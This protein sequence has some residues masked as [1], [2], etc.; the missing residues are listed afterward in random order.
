ML[1]FG[2]LQQARV[3]RLL[4]FMYPRRIPPGFTEAKEVNLYPTLS[5]PPDGGD[6]VVIHVPRP[7]EYG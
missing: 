7:M 3:K 4:L 5:A 2:W 1:C 6:L